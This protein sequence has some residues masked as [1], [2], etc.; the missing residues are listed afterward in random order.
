MAVTDLTPEY[1]RSVISY[2][3]ETG[4]FIWTKRV[5]NRVKVGSLAGSKS[6]NGYVYIFVKGKSYSAHRLA[7][8]YEYGRWPSMVDHINGD[9]ADNRLE[10]LRECTP[11]QN[12]AN[13][14]RRKD[15]TVGLKGVKRANSGF[16]ASI[17]HQKST[18]FLGVFKTPEEAHRAYVAASR[19]LFGDYARAA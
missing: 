1:L 7:W 5:A 13:A 4:L 6:P 9:A 15:S 12:Q 3:R 10:N 11:S 19:G 18:H 8:L 2:D 14:R 17:Q 16:A